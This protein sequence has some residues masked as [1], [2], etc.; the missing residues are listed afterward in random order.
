VKPGL[1]ALLAGLVCL[2]PMLDLARPNEVVDMNKFT[3]VFALPAVLG[4]AT[5]LTH[6]GAGAMIAATLAKLMPA[7]GASPSYGFMLITFSASLIAI[8]ATIPGSIAIVTPTLPGFEAATGLPLVA[9]LNAML[10]GLQSPFFAFEAVPVMVG[11]MMGKVAASA[12]TRILVPLAI[13]GL[14]VVAPLQMAWL[15]LIGVM[16]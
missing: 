4:V 16:P 7:S 14:L 15:K 5:V 8:G 12:A 2:L 1:I 11:L 6:S 3:S 13:T 10:I 9:G